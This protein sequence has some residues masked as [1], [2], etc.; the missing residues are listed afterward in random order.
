MGREGKWGGV[1]KMGNARWLVGVGN[2][3]I[4]WKRPI[5]LQ[6]CI[7]TDTND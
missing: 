2:W 6:I 7:Y 1:R 4:E 5:L 3:V